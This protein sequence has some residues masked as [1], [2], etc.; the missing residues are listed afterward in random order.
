MESD[1]DS[2]FPANLLVEGEDLL[3]TPAIDE[4]AGYLPLRSSVFSDRETFFV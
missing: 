2:R 4:D 1:G 3:S